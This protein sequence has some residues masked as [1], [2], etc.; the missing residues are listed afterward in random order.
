[1]TVRFLHTA[2]WQIE[3]SFRNF[4][5]IASRLRE[6]RLETGRKVMDLADEE[7]VDFVVIAGDLFDERYPDRDTITRV[8]NLLTDYPNIPV[9]IIAGNHDPT[10]AGS[11]YLKPPFSNKDDNLIIPDEPGVFELPG[12]EEAVLLASPLKQKSSTNDP[13]DHFPDEPS[14]VIRIGATHGQLMIPEKY[15]KD[16]FPIKTDA[17]EDH[18]LDYLALGD[19]HS[20]YEHNERCGYSGTHEPAAFGDDA[21]VLAIEIDER[22]SKP[23]VEEHNVSE[24]TWAVV[25]QDLTPDGVLNELEKIL[26]ELEPE[27]TLVKLSVTG[28]VEAEKRR[29]LDVLCE[30]MDQKFTGSVVETGELSQAASIEDLCN[31]LKN[32]PSL[33]GAIADMIRIKRKIDPDIP[34]ETPDGNFTKLDNAIIDEIYT[35]VQSDHKKFDYFSNS[36]G[37]RET[38]SLLPTD[39]DRALQELQRLLDRVEP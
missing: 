3:K 26:D 16:S 6:V 32:H 38:Q 11:F 22:E 34:D 19:W 12:D 1:M 36:D 8:Y 30:R 5:D 37:E 7:D 14:D 4:P 13:T 39:V 27:K 17:V 2:D 29:K 28:T 18:N 15:S 20:R 25:E 35:S 23:Q 33:T 21:R 31:R 10:S 24:L 9:Y